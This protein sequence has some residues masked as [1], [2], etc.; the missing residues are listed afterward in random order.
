MTNSFS[1]LFLSSWYPTIEYPTHGIFIRNHA[2]ALSKYCQVI[3]I[4]VYS[5]Q[6]INTTEFEH[7]Q[8][9]NLD[10]YILAFPKSKIPVLKPIVH[11]FKYLYYYYRLSKLVKKHYQNIKFAQINVIYPVSLF[12]PL[13]KKI[14]RIK[15]YTVFEQWTGYLKEDNLYKGFI[16]KWVT[17]D[18]IKNADKVWCLCEYQ[19]AAMLNHGLNAS[20]EI[21]GNVVNTEFFKPIEKSAN[22]KD[23]KTFIHISTLDDRQKNIS[24]ILRVFSELE[25]EGHSFELIIIGGTTENI[26]KC[27]EIAQHYHLQNVKFKGIVPQNELPTYLHNADA[28]VMF[29]NYETFCVVVY[30]AISTGTYVISTNVAD[31]DKVITEKY[32]CLI[33]P[34]DEKGLKDAILKVLHN[35][36]PKSSS[37]EAHQWI[38]SHFSSEVIGKKLYDYYSTRI[39]QEK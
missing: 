5:S 21:M 11:F 19:K 1:V 14:L 32:G 25:K 13:I 4:Y 22:S 29:S 7:T 31:L 3:V 12:F 18:I 34:K 8:T 36:V 27:R 24:G 39:L 33:P 6:E 38:K 10:E 37:T 28:L 2:L 17:K 30:E 23:K 35:K 9:G 15:H 16:Q 20:Y 26:Q